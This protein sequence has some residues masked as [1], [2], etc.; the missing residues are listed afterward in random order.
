M[1][2]ISMCSNAHCADRALCY[3]FTATPNEWRQAYAAFAP[4]PGARRCDDFVPNAGQERRE[5]R[6]VPRP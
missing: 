1:P 2:D 3:R 4:A 6:D 5:A